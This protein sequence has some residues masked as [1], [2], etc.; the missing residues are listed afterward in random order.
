MKKIINLIMVTLFVGVASVAQAGLIIDISESEGNVNALY[1]GSVDLNATEGFA[2]G[3]S[4]YSGFDAT[5]GGVGFSSDSVDLYAINLSGWTSFGAGAGNFWDGSI[6][7]ALSLFIGVDPVIGLPSGYVS[8]DFISGFAVKFGASLASL[9]FNGGSYVS[10]FTN[11]DGDVGDF[12]IVNVT[13][14]PEPITLG[15]F[16]LGLAGLG[17]RRRKA[18]K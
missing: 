4:A 9:G 17:L 2:G 16:A 8:G 3:F 5:S 10:V 12:V 6:G 11:A 18:I 13:E 7:D 15:L 14:V 1:Y